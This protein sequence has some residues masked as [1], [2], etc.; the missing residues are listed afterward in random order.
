M[1]ARHA[2]SLPTV[3]T[4]CFHGVCLHAL[5]TH[6]SPF[7]CRLTCSLD[8]TGLV[9]QLSRGGTVLQDLYLQDGPDR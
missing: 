7:P 4:S 6:T 9:D 1:H 8:V 2:A 5:L 3:A